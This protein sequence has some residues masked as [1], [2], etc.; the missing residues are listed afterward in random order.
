M[1]A[2]KPF[3]K[4]DLGNMIHGDSLEVLS[5]WADGSVDLIMTSPPFAL[6]QQ[7]EYGNVHADVYCDWFKPFAR[8]FFR[9]LKD[10]GSLVIDIGGTWVDKQPT[11][12]LYHFKLLIMLCEEMGFHLAQDY[13]WWN[14][15][16]LPNPTEWVTVRRIRVTDAVNTVWQLSK[17]PWPKASNLRVLQP[18]RTGM[19]QLHTFR[20]QKPANHNNNNQAA[21]K[22]LWNTNAA[23]PSNLIAL[24]NRGHKNN[25]YIRY[26]REN[27]LPLHP[28]RFPS[29]LPEYFIRMLT[30]PGDTVIDP[31]GGS[32]MTGEVCQRLKRKWYCIDLSREYLE[33]ALGRFKNNPIHKEA[34]NDHLKGSKKINSGWEFPYYVV[35]QPGYFWDGD[36]DDLLRKDGGKERQS[37][38]RL[39]SVSACLNEKEKK[40]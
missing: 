12:S 7:K 21:K 13:Y 29:E 22:F 18:S 17:T 32:C 20:Y 38:R 31:F 10:S 16:R 24:T 4:T 25:A 3:Y 23:I 2:D 19:R 35:P 8:Q 11:R 28:A 26:C 9:V 5:T 39:K 36:Q 27:K 30:D 34:A 37:C 15:C 40:G 33:G 14:P 6:L 1:K